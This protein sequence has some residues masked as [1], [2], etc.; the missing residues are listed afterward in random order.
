MSISNKPKKGKFLASI[1]YHFQTRIISLLFWKE[2]PLKKEFNLLNRI[3]IALKNIE[4]LIYLIRL[5]GHHCF[6]IVLVDSERKS[7]TKN[8][9]K[10]F[11]NYYHY[12]WGW[13]P[14]LKILCL[15]TMNYKQRKLFS[16]FWIRN[17][18]IFILI[19]ILKF[20]LMGLL[21]NRGKVLDWYFLLKYF[22][23]SF[24]FDLFYL[25]PFKKSDSIRKPYLFIL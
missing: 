6:W 5:L 20:L 8:E 23:F 16:S 7:T 10:L 21:L 13:F 1:N 24:N 11:D 15:V 9:M 18:V 3:I 19:L 22:L 25:F 14:P 4:L 2:L 12:Q 17:Y